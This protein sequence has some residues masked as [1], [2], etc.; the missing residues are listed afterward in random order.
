MRYLLAAALVLGAAAGASSALASPQPSNPDW[1]REQQGVTVTGTP[2]SVAASSTAVV[3]SDGGRRQVTFRADP[4]MTAGRYIYLCS[5]PMSNFNT[6]GPTPT[7]VTCTAGTAQVILGPGDAYTEEKSAQAGWR[8]IS[9]T[10][11]NTLY[12]S[13]SR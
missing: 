9:S 3:A 10:G 5:F 12:V 11:T 7:P 6:P 1:V 2:V 4:A 13:V 8:G